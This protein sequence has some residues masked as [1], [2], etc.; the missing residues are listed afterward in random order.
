MSS[1]LEIKG[2]RPTGNVLGSGSYGEVSEVEWCSTVC[3]AKRLHD[4]FLRTLSPAELDKMIN[5]F[6]K[7]CQIWSGLKHPNIVQF[8][9]NYYSANSRVPMSVLEK[10][11]TSLRHYLED[12]SKEDFLLPDKV[13]I[14]R[15]VSQGLCYLHDHNPPLV[16]RDL[17]PNN[18]LLN[19]WTF[20]TK[21]TDFGITR[22][23]NLSKLTRYSSVK[24]TIAFMSP[25]ALDV[26]PRYTEKLDVFSFGNCITTTLIHEWPNPSHPTTFNSGKMI[27][28]TEYERRMHQID[29]MSAREKDLLLPLITR[30]LEGD[31]TIR[32]SSAELVSELKQ[33][34]STL[35]STE[36][37]AISQVQQAMSQLSLE[38][39]QKT[40]LQQL[41]QRIQH[42]D[43]ERQRHQTQLA[44]LQQENTQLQET[45]NQVSCKPEMQDPSSL[46]SLDATES[47]DTRKVSKIVYSVAI[48]VVSF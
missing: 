16:H 30:C 41:E 17:T 8:L 15:Q 34:E 22:A 1:V 19:E 35:Q 39:E 45:L 3:A 10:M 9:G 23:I 12:H 20:L 29:L 24:G 13:S 18:I 32:P 46:T 26:P 11:D 42:Y 27:V 36:P 4:I 21:L 47:T 25:E 33:I 6:D 43:E 38:R 31:A 44:Q 48:S 40:Q 7:E 5:D 28:R 14:L 2:V 37:S